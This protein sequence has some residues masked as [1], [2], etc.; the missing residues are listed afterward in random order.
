VALGGTV[1]VIGVMEAA[2]V[3]VSKGAAVCARLVAGR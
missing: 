2:A 1:G 3:L